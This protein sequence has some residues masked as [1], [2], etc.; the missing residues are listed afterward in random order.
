MSRRCA[1]RRG[2]KAAGLNQHVLGYGE[3]AERE[4][5][6]AGVAAPVCR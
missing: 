6:A 4:W 5:A 1:S 3:V 2:E